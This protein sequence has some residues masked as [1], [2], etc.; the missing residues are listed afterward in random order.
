MTD[1]WTLLVS[2]YKAAGLKNQYAHV[3]VLIE[4]NLMV[5]ERLE[6]GKN[7][8]MEGITQCARAFY[9]ATASPIM[10]RNHDEPAVRW[11]ANQQGVGTKVL[12]AERGGGGG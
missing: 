1:T 3:A 5:F 11:F 9:A 12:C 6:D 10:A 8:G 7:A 4:R 2:P